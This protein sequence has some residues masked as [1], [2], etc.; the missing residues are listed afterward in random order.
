MT[1]SRLKKYKKADSIVNINTK[2]TDNTTYMRQRYTVASKWAA[3]RI[4]ELFRKN[5]EMDAYV[6]CPEYGDYPYKLLELTQNLKSVYCGYYKLK[7]NLED[8]VVDQW[9]WQQLSSEFE[10]YNIYK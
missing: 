8:T 9:I 4:L 3:K 10:S 5:K 6:F 1:T 2:Y 7:N